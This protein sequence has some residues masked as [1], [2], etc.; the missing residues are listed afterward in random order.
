MLSAQ[1]FADA[2][3]QE[4]PRLRRSAW[5]IAP[6]DVEPDD[7]VQDVLERAWRAR[8]SFRGDSLLSTWLHRILIN[9]A[10]DLARKVR[11][12]I[13]LQENLNLPA[14][15]VE[16]PAGAIERSEDGD[17]LRAALS[18][19]SVNDRMILVL[20]DGEEWSAEQIRVLTGW[21]IASVYKR[22]QRARLRLLMALSESTGVIQRQSREC[23]VARGMLGQYFD[24]ALDPVAV[25]DVDSHLL[26]CSHCPPLAQALLGLRSALT[27]ATNVPEIGVKLS[28]SI[29]LLGRGASSLNEPDQP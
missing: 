9:R 1:E 20:H 19:L 2:V 29:A 24:G 10:R 7:L 21:T 17:K 15:R 26:R 18:V 12:G 13:A 4:L 16:N 8:E 28:T 11:P 5:R 22:L 25:Q 23:R 14:L 6:A 3:A 27:K